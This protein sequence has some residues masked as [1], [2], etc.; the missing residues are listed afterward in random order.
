VKVI[1]A[2]SRSYEDEGKDC[3][4]LVRSAMEMYADAFGEPP[5]EVVSGNAIGI[6]QA[7]ERWADANKIPVTTFIPDW[8]SFGKSAGPRRN[9][10]MAKYA[11]AL[12]A[13][14]DGKSRG[15]KNM[16]D[17]A[18]TAGLAVLIINTDPDASRAPTSKDET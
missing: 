2:G 4:V 16:I 12:V 15:T 18:E 14:W 8:Q 9:R 5:K 1:I 13:I 11:D 7:G 17:E 10:S 6:D 3:D